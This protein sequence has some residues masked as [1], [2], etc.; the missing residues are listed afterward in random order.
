MA[1]F[2]KFT[3]VSFAYDGMAGNLL[4]DVEAY[5]PEGAWTGI[6]GANGC[7]KTTLLRLAAGE[8]EP[9]S[10]TIGSLGRA[11]YV[12]QRTDFPP[13]DLDDFLE[14]HDAGA[15]AWRA[16]LGVDPSWAGRWDT[17]SHGE[18]KR[19]QIA[20]AL[21]REPG[22]LALDEPTNHLDEMAKAA[23]L[24]ALEAF[25]GAG[26]VVSHDRDFLDALC[27]QCLFIFPPTATM[28]PGGVTEGQEQDRREQS[29]RRARDT[30][31]KDDARHLR[32]AAQRRFELAQQTAKKNK[33][34]RNARIDPQDHDGR[35]KRNLA[36]LTGKNAW[37]VTQSAALGKRAAKTEASRHGLAPRKEYEMGFW[38]N[39][40]EKS[41]RDYVLSLDVGEITLGDGRILRFPE[42]RVR[43]DDRIAITGDN[44]IG[45]STF[46]RHVLPHANVPEEKLLVVP[47]EISETESAKILAEV[48]ELGAESLG[49][50]MTSVSR[51]GSRPGRLLASES[52]SPGEIRK[53]LLAMGVDR[54]IHLLVMD[55]PTN[56]LDLP[57]IECL[58]EALAECPCA[59]LLVSHDRR[60]L[61]KITRQEW[62]FAE[63]EPGVVVLQVRG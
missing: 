43:P 39:G 47:Q 10:G 44:G 30:E 27:S 57:G 18:R 61:S 20:V 56:H 19:A 7:G 51:L 5:F 53:I 52:P 8:L 24:K 54:G 6:V 16:R 50:V 2:L 36:K 59:M 14:A 22:V 45:K 37:A 12:V 32:E 21:W 29:F 42:I 15:I 49:R 31:A 48:K 38:L 23:L 17:L 34:A 25:S 62:H 63:A 46:L 4:E 41:Q 58:E 60:F 3:N 11:C 13:D 33:A 9:S 28:R 35:A 1:R 26:L 55:E 40:G